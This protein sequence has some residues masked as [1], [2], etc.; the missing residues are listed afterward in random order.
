MMRAITPN[1]NRLTSAESTCATSTQP[2]S[3]R[4][5]QLHS[6]DVQRLLH[7]RLAASR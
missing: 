3:H 2:D 5:D 6:Q 1:Q 7:A 4:T